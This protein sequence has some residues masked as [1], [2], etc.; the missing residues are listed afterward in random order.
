MLGHVL[1]ISAQVNSRSGVPALESVTFG[2]FAEVQ[3]GTSSAVSSVRR[4]WS[5]Y[6]GLRHLKVENDSLKQ[7]LAV[8]QVAIQEQRTLADRSRSVAQLHDLRDHAN[9]RTTAA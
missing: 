5:G 3:R 8:A 4:L 7:Q 1:L 6:I 2:I 9:L